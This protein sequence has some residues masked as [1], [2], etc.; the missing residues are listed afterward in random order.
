[1][2]LA[3]DHQLGVG[4]ERAGRWRKP[5]GAV[6]ADADDGEPSRLLTVP[7]HNATSA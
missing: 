5:L 1:V 7:A 2:T 6:L 3:A 4:D